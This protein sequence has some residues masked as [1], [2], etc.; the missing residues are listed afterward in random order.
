[1]LMPG[2]AARSGSGNLAMEAGDLAREIHRMILLALK[3]HN[4]G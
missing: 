4:A 2:L 3:I 1:M